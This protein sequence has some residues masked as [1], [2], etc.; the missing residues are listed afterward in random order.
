[1][2]GQSQSGGG[3]ASWKRVSPILL[4]LA[5]A[6][7]QLAGSFTYPIAKY[8]LAQ[9]EPFT[10]AAY[11]FALA[12]LLLLGLT[13]LQRREPPVARRD[14]WRIGLL[15]LLIIPCNQ[16]M[17]LLGQSMTAAGHGAF[18]F[19]STPIWVFLLAML[20]LGE[21]FRWRRA[22]GVVLAVVGVV[23]ILMSGGLEVGGEYVLGDTLILV[24]VLAWSYYTVLGKRLVQR[25][26]ALRMTAYALTCGTVVY[27]PYGIYRAAIFDYS[28]ASLHAWLAVAYLAIAL[29]LVFYV[30][31]YWVL[32]Y[33]EPSRLAVYHNIQPV[34]ATIAAYL[35][36]GERFDLWFAAGGVVVLAGVLVSETG[37]VRR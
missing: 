36:L 33:W 9:I 34:I 37:R 26:G 18:L 30:L 7:L 27:L 17:Y 31:W 12:S 14:W 2:T 3:T 29:S 16:L 8:G 28:S 11:R 19:G 15:G 35:W 10:F 13:R 1:L 24:A 25:Y 20:H 23:L 21:R 4:A 22:V 32:K 6:G 5:V